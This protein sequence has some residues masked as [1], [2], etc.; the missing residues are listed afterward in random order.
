MEFF[1]NKNLSPL[2]LIP[3]NFSFSQQQP[4]INES[5]PLFKPGIICDRFEKFSEYRNSYQNKFFHFIDRK[6]FNDTNKLLDNDSIFN[7]KH[8][9]IHEEKKEL[10]LSSTNIELSALKDKKNNFMELFYNTEKVLK[11]LNKDFQLLKKSM[12]KD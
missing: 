6:L 8:K 7:E 10:L 12:K 1:K 5:P 9:H 2:N 3:F 11:E 4:T